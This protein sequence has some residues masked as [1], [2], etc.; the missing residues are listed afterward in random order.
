MANICLRIT[1]CGRCDRQKQKEINPYVAD[2]H[3]WSSS[4]VH[5]TGIAR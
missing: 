4:N 1:F 2:N 3:G 5:E